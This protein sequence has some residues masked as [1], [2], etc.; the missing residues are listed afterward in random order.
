MFLCRRIGQLNSRRVGLKCAQLYFSWINTQCEPQWE[1]EKHHINAVHE[2]R[3][4]HVCKVCGK[5]YYALQHLKDHIKRIH[6]DNPDEFQC[7]ICQ[8]ILRQKSALKMHR[9]IIH[10]KVRDHKCKVCDYAASCE[11]N[12]SKHTRTVH[13]KIDI[14]REYEGSINKCIRKR[15]KKSILK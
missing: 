1:R 5:S 6:E 13:L 14:F 2:K 10:E 12:L 3:R 8:K 15:R 4:D 11:G 9:K 7:D